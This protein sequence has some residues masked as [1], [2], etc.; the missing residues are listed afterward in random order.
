MKNITIIHK[1][2]KN[3]DSNIIHDKLFKEKII[4]EYDI[5]NILWFSN[6]TITRKFF[7]GSIIKIYAFKNIGKN[8]TN[9]E[10][11]TTTHFYSSNDYAN[12]NSISCL[13]YPNYKKWGIKRLEFLKYIDEF[14]MYQGLNFIGLLTKNPNSIVKIY[15]FN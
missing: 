8:L 13:I 11:N 10:L 3:Y 9:M 7:N 12:D 15:K 6:S 14:P 4:P 5:N 1:F 2:N